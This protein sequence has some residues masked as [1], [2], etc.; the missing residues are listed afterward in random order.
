MNRVHLV[1]RHRPNGSLTALELVDLALVSATFAVPTRIFL[2]GP[3]VLHAV[4]ATVHSLA[5]SLRG[6][7]DSITLY[8]IEPL[9]VQRSDWI[10][11]GLTDAQ[12]VAP[13][14]LVEPAEYLTR[15]RAAEVILEG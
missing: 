14:E 3:G 1:L 5:Y 7:L 8:E 10:D 2:E 13:V 9:V 4:T 15:L 12:C 6:R 11:F